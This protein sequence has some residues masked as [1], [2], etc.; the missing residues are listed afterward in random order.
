MV[1]VGR[2][3]EVCR[4]GLKVNADKRE[5]MVLGVEEGLR[6]EICRWST[7]GE[8]VRVQIFGLGCG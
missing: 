1:I 3:V 5:V 7:I 6:C 8:S 2:Y 4:R